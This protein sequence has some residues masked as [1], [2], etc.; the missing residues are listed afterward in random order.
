MSTRYALV[1]GV[2]NVTNVILLDDP[3]KYTPAAGLTL[4]L[5]A[6]GVG[7]GWRFAN[8]T[9][10]PPAPPPP[11]PHRLVPKSVIID[12][13]NA[14]GLLQAASTALNADLYT[15]ERWYAAD[16]ACVYADDPLVIG[17][18]QS[19]GADPSVILR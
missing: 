5:D 8:S 17:L 7:P 12:R 2:G 14:A 18:L 11:D 10:T 6:V 3:G 1:D 4:Q 19:I 16:R 9:F 13:L 15:R